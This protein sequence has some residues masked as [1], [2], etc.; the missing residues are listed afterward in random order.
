MAR[1]CFVSQAASSSLSSGLWIAV[2]AVAV[3]MVLFGIGMTVRENWSG[4]RSSTR[5]QGFAPDHQ[6]PSYPSYEFSTYR[7]QQMNPRLRAQRFYVNNQ[8]SIDPENLYSYRP[9]LVPSF[10]P[11]PEYRRV[12]IVYDAERTERKFPLFGRPT[13]P[14][15]NRFDYY[16]LD[17]TIHT[18]P[19]PLVNHNGLE[20]VSGN[21]VRVQGYPNEFHVYT[22]YE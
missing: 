17:D 18:N 11:P 16:V 13:Y 7:A 2:I 22:Y 8:L 21:R 9:D 4:S 10:A 1:K 6:L 19:L 3:L 12:G 5:G 14:G 15:G 20:L